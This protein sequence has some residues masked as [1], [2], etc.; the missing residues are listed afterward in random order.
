MVQKYVL[1]EYVDYGRLKVKEL[2]RLKEKIQLCL[3]SWKQK[4]LSTVGKTTLINSIIHAILNYI[5]STFKIPLT[6]YKVLDA[7]ACRFWWGGVEDK[8][9]YCALKNWRSISTPKEIG[10]LGFRLFKDINIILLAKIGW[11]L[12]QRAKGLALN[13]FKTKYLIGKSFWS[14]N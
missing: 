4:L 6:V 11:Q 12:A 2:G 3:A 8:K 14:C 1:G 5:M 10:G 13:I 7:V 9:R